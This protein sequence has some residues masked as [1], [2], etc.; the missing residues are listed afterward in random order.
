MFLD[1]S[2]TR[3]AKSHGAQLSIHTD[4]VPQ[5]C[6]AEYVLRIANGERGSATAACSLVKR[7][8]GSDRLS[9]SVGIHWQ[10]VA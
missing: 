3:S 1:Y 2:Q 5:I 4:A 8:Q 7:L 6:I 10:L 9:L